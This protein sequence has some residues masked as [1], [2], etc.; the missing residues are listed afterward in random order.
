MRYLLDT[1]ICI[2]IRRERPLQVRERLARQ[3][4]G[5]VGLSL[6]TWGELLCGA[7]RSQHTALAREKLD[8][9]VAMI[10]LLPLP[11]EAAQHYGDIR[12][13]LAGAGTPI[14]A[15]ELWIAAHA[16]AAD[17]TVVTNNTREF[18][19]VDGLKLENW[20]Q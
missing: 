2:Y 18:E 11:L 12:A 6:I 3:R 1:N 14:G 13:A 19:R 20:A 4:P 10:P 15:N 8:A 16:R 9:I 5:S 17:L 7:A